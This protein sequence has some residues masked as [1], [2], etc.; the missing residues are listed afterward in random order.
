MVNH[1]TNGRH[2]SVLLMM[3]QVVIRGPEGSATQARASLDSG[4]EASFILEQLAK[5][6]HLPRCKGPAILC[7]GGS[8]WQVRTKGLVSVEIMDTSQA[9]KV[10]SVEAII[11]P[12]IT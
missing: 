10:H 8:M 4:A 5:Q 11:L 1:H 3:C 7:M 9:G 12:T 6:L 2:K